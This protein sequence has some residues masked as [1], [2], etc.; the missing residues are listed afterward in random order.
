M[1]VML[2]LSK[3]ERR[4]NANALTLCKAD[5]PPHMVR[6]PHH[7]SL[8]LSFHLQNFPNFIAQDDKMPFA[9]FS[10]IYQFINRFSYI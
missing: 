10:T 8:F 4:H 3:H 2:R 9:H 7:D 6:V 1:G 5:R